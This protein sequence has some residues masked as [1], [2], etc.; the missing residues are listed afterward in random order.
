MRK[1]PSPCLVW[2]VFW[3]SNCY[4]GW[5]EWLFR[6][7][8]RGLRAG[9]EYVERYRIAWEWWNF[10]EG[11]D[12][13]Y[14]YGYFPP[15]HKMKPLKF[16]DGGV[17]LIISRNPFAKPYGGIKWFLVGVYGGV[18]VL[19]K[20]QYYG[21]MVWDTIPEEQR[22][23]LSEDAREQIRDEGYY[24]V[25][26][27]KEYS[28]PMPSYMSIDLQEYLGVS[29]LGT[30]FFKYLN[31]RECLKLIDDAITYAGSSRGTCIDVREALKR[32]KNARRIIE[33]YINGRH[34]SITVATRSPEGSLKDYE[35]RKHD[36]RLLEERKPVI[37]YAKEKYRLPE[38]IIEEVLAGNLE[39]IEEGL[40]LV[41]RQYSIPNGR[42]DILARDKQGRLV[43][44]EVKSGLA[45]DA[46]LTQLLYYMS[47]IGKGRRVRG[48]IVAE[49]FTHK[50]VHAAN[51]LENINLVKI[52]PKITIEVVKKI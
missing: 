46:T 8:R 25:K 52:K 27:L 48:I 43:V 32:L 11:F 5:D 50:L 4:R 1:E 12:D 21:G 34:P 49:E 10:Y 15:I 37:G 22:R 33:E 35:L 40:E 38:R 39:V 13:K 24:Y 9:Y 3:S 47:M 26:A 45:D 2:K 28:T 20:R 41:A 36:I 14:Y 51:S 30:A 42:I 18:E 23:L 31:A 6:D 29:H 44:I 17:F 16:I 19:E 7:L